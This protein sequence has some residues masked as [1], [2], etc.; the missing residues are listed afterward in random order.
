VEELRVRYSVGRKLRE[1]TIESWF[2]PHETSALRE[3]KFEVDTGRFGMNAYV[4]GIIVG[5][6]NCLRRL[7][8]LMSRDVTKHS[9]SR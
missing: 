1:L 2:N 8:R 9:A 5:E 4:V 6:S 3:I 7:T